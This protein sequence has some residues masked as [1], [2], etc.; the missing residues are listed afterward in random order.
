MDPIC[1][2]PTFSR[3][4]RADAWEEDDGISKILGI[5][6]H[7]DWDDI[8]VFFSA[9]RLWVTGQHRFSKKL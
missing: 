7:N 8:S 6:D 3:F 1:F 4:S 9:Y 2:L 5:G